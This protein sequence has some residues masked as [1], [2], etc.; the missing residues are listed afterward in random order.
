MTP[1]VSPTSK[2]NTHHITLADAAG[3]IYGLVINNEGR[4]IERRP[5]QNSQYVP[6]TQNDWSSGR[7]L[8]FAIEDRS[9]FADSK[10]LNT[11]RAGIVSLGGQEKYTNGHRQMEQFLPPSATGVTWQALTGSNRFIA[12]KV[13]ATA[14]GNRKRIYIWLRKRGTPTA[15]L[16]VWLLQNNAGD[17]GTTLKLVSVAVA[18]VDDTISMLYECTFDSVQAVT[19]TTDYWVQVSAGSGDDSTNHWEVGTDASRT[20]A[21]TKA[22]ANGS[23]GWANTTYDLY[24]RLVDDLDILG[25]KFF[26]YKSQLYMVTRPTTTNAPKLYMNGYRGV[27]TGSGQS[28]TILKDTTQNW[29]TNELAGKLLLIIDGPNSEWQQPY[30]EIISNDSD[31][32]VTTAFGKAHVAATTTYVILGDDTWKEITGHGLTALPSDVADAGDVLYFAQGDAV[33]MRRM[34][35]RN[36]AGVWT[37]T[38]AEED[39][40]AKLLLV[41]EDTAS[42]GTM[43]LKAND[44]DNSNR[45][46]VAI[47]KTEAFGQRLKYP[48]LINP[49]DATTNWTGGA[50]TTLTA[51]TSIYKTGSASIK[52]TIGAAAANTFAYLTITAGISL[53]LQKRIRFWIYSSGVLEIGQLK[54]R[55]S[56][57]TDAS[58]SQQTDIDLPPIEANTWTQI[59]LPFKDNSAGIQAIK[60]I[61]FVKTFATAINI[62]IDGLETLPGGSEIPLG[63]D[64]QRINGLELYGDPAVPWVFRSGSVGSI[65]NGTFVPVPLREYAMVE[66]VMNGLGHAV[67]RVYLYF[68]FLQGTEEYYRSN[69]DDIGPNRD[70]GL[71]AN[72]Q[73]YTTSIVPYPDRL[74]TNYDAGGAGY[75]SIMSRKGGGYHEE[76]RSDSLGKRIRSIF[77]QVIPGYMSDRLWFSEGEDIAFIPLAGNTINELTDSTYRFTHE[78]VLEMAWIGD[79]QQRL[80]STVKLGLENTTAARCIE[81]D[82]KLDEETTWTAATTNFTTGP[83]QTLN[84]NKIGKRL[85][86][87]F[88]PQTNNASLTPR[89]TSINISTT[90]QPD[91]RYSYSMSF[92]FQDNGRDLLNQVEN[93]TRAETLVAQLDAWAA[94]KTPLTMRSVTEAM[95]NK[96]VFLDPLPLGTLSFI[97]HEQQEKQSGTLTATEPL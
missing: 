28:Q 43:I 1:S 36:L 52:A 54:L 33:K 10:R 77:V 44:Y 14:T 79:D 34:Q 38:F 17:P 47:T 29:A 20:Q 32:I 69:L 27:A 13:T 12:Y 83:V 7:A 35:E 55:L 3:T 50:S 5:R 30:R 86:I 94:A 78:G 19:A 53:Y 93:Y 64:M 65:E 15:A 76:Y 90:V 2:T 24:Y 91:I 9:R 96:T 23:T 85:K 16:G 4:A 58:T 75:S 62:Y 60:S 25:A 66:N 41:Y 46:S 97:A 56:A 63:D 61:G 89:I 68:S 39:N 67:W 51:D 84:L 48:W 42:R 57:L 82:Y 21:K 40:Y 71:P 92:V 80:F 59:T 26:T 11:R 6:F 73:G 22:S 70:E 87:R 88:R 81:W 37:R 49:C 95:D 8:K 45:P 72:R 31:E 18:S 74:I